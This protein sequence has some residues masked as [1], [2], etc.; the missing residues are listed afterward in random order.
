MVLSSSNKFGL[1]N[2]AFHEGRVKSVQEVVVTR[3]SALRIWLLS[4]GM[5]ALAA[6]SVAKAQQCG[7]TTTCG[8]TVIK[9]VY[10]K[11]QWWGTI[12]VSNTGPTTLSSYTV[13]FDV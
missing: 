6:P 12:T 11:A 1:S 3:L 10:D 9:N 7:V 5:F 4:I 2:E 8:I 13:E